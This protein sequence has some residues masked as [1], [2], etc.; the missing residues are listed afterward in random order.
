VAISIY[1]GQVC[2][3]TIKALFIFVIVALLLNTLEVL[4]YGES[5]PLGEK[6][7]L[8]LTPLLPMATLGNDG[9]GN[10][11][12]KVTNNYTKDIAVRPCWNNAVYLTTVNDSAR[13][14]SIEEFRRGHSLGW[15]GPEQRPVILAPG[16]TGTFN[17]SF[18]METFAFLAGKNKSVIGH[19][20]GYIVSTNDRF[21]SYSKPFPVPGNLATPPWTDLGTQGFFSVTPL[22]KKLSTQ[23]GVTVGLLIFIPIE[24]KNL[25]S[26]ACVADTNLVI[27]FLE[28]KG[29]PKDRRLGWETINATGKLLQPGESVETR[30]RSYT[31][32]EFLAD[33]GYKPGDKLIAVVGGRVPSTNHV[34]QCY[35]APFELPP[36]PKSQPTK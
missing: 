28:R 14:V 27:F 32:T 18:S 20:T 21:E 30:R 31:T 24:I 15:G 29:W 10:I 3:M 5:Q 22:L 33:D 6:S 26:E 16:Q 1:F 8:T 19:I 34:F 9:D 13:K 25:T 4:A 7:Y 2:H 36:L 17:A 12:F 11:P 35:S 23:S